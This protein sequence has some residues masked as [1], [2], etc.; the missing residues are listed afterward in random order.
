[1]GYSFDDAATLTIT[2]ELQEY[3]IGTNSK[4]RSREGEQFISEELRLYC[5]QDFYV[6]FERES[7]PAHPCIGGVYHVFRR[8]CGKI[9]LQRMTANGILHLSAEGDI[10]K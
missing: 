4:T 5:T 1:M 6:R 9:F 8:K 7:G 10:M 3:K 2:A